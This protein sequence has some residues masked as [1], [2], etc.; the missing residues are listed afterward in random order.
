MKTIIRN[1]LKAVVL[2]VIGVLMVSTPVFAAGLLTPRDSNLPELQIK[3]HVV[4]VTIEDGYAITT[5]EQ[6]FYNPHDRD[7]EAIY[8]F[9]VPEKGSVS[10]F[11]MWIDGKPIHGEVLE[12]KKAREVYE[13]QKAKNKNAGLTE[14]NE[15]KTFEISV[16]PVRANQETKIRFGYIQ[17]AHVDTSIGRYVYPLEEGGVDD[18]ALAFWTTNEKVTGRFSFDLVLKSGYPIASLR[19]P[20]HPQAQI[21]QEGDV[22]KVHM[23][24]LT[25]HTAATNVQDP[26][27][28]INNANDAVENQSASA[29]SVD[30][31]FRL[32]R[33]IVVYYRQAENLPGAV[34]LVAYKEDA[35]KRGTFMMTVTPGMDLKTIQEGRDWVF[36]LDISGSMSGKYA[37]LAEGVSR[38]IKSMNPNDRFRIVLFNTN[39]KELTSGFVTATPGNVERYTQAVAQVKPGESTNLF[40]GLKLGLHSLDSDRTTSILLVTDGVANVGETKQRSFI[41]LLKNYDVRL[42]TFVMGNSANQPLLDVLTR[43]SNGFSISVS[44]SDDIIG[45]IMEAQSKVNFQALHG[46]KVKVSGVKVSDITPEELGNVYRGQQ[47][48]IFGHYF[49]S[50]P[51]T[52]TLTGKISGEEKVY[53]T[54]FDFPEVATDNPEIERLWAYATI[55]RLSQEIADFGEESDIKQSI[56]D[57]GVE[58]GLVTDYTSMIVLEE[59]V[60]NE[61]GIDRQNAKRLQ[62]EF[63]AQL[64]RSS[65]NVRSNR[66]DNSQPMFSHNRPSFSGGV[67]AFDP[68]SLG[69]L[70]PLLWGISRRKKNK[71]ARQTC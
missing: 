1:K 15:Y 31:S 44:N 47:L 71:G 36:V 3:D 25:N 56:T 22:W 18:Y 64:L 11:T 26:A 37:T 49:G 52:V 67:G 68:V 43:V 21:T 17:P 46:A 4:N 55:E 59:E 62:K 28:T 23:D 20:S 58:Y 63:D 29:A 66:V 50:G 14:K 19:L 16:F 57:L 69:L 38:A 40:D 32:N 12:K 54:S 8:S 24:N 42:F 13:D 39:A 70:T 65:R 60:F 41:E 7:L 53:Q 9:P 34:D 33:D 5:V 48:V 35:S 45:K 61:L 30:P 6:V 27:L 51:A 10:E 2:L